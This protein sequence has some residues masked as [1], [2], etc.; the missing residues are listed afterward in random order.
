MESNTVQLIG[1]FWHPKFH[2]V[3]AFVEDK[4][5]GEEVWAWY[6]T[7]RGV[8][9]CGALPFFTGFINRVAQQWVQPTGFFSS[10]YSN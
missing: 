6:L 3:I 1:A 8:P 4:P 10:A 7:C 2:L 9:E 5:E